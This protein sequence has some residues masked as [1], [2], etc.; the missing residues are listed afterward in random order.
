MK[1]KIYSN[2]TVREVLLV[3]KC[4]STKQF[5]YEI[6]KDGFNCGRKYEGLKPLADRIKQ[7]SRDFIYKIID[8]NIRD[9][10]RGIYN[11]RKALAELL[12]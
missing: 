5:K 2:R 6:V 3:R 4:N 9:D 11:N 7:T 1:S 12:D 10:L 8:K